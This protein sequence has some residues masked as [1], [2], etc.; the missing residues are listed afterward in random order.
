MKKSSRAKE[1][2]GGIVSIAG[3]FNPVAVQSRLRELGIMVNVRDEAIRISPHFYN[4]EDEIFKLF[5]A[6]DT[7]LISGSPAYNRFD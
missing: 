3:N 6:L 2:R 1:E 5:D 4:T 7:I